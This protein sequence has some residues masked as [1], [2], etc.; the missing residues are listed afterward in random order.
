MSFN[1]VYGSCKDDKKAREIV[2]VLRSDKLFYG[3][4]R[5]KNS[6]YQLTDSYKRLNKIRES[7]ND[8]HTEVLHILSTVGAEEQVVI[9]DPFEHDSLTGILE[10]NYLNARNKFTHGCDLVTT[11]MGLLDIVTLGEER[12]YIVNNQSKVI[13]ISNDTLDIDRELRPAHN[14]Y[15]MWRAGALGKQFL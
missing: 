12:I 6:E 10:T 9:F 15:K 13:E 7:K 14:L 2:V 8:L 11:Q 4:R 1:V 3:K 5:L